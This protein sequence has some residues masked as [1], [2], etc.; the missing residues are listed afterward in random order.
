MEVLRAAGEEAEIVEAAAEALAGKVDVA[1]AV[2]EEPDLAVAAA[3]LL[4]GSVEVEFV[5]DQE[6]EDEDEEAAAAD[7]A[8]DAAAVA[9]AVDDDLEAAAEAGDSFAV[10]VQRYWVQPSAA[11]RLAV[12]G[13]AWEAPAAA[14]EKLVDVVITDDGAEE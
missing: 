8:A 10:P 7:A 3:A 9:M 1:V 12:R 11:A 6:E 13:G 5:L 4:P 2:E 14:A